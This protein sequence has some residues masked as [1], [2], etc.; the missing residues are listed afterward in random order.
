MIHTLGHQHRK[1]ARRPTAVER[2]HLHT[3]QHRQRFVIVDQ[4][5]GAA[6]AGARAQR[7]ARPR[8]PVA[9]LVA[10]QTLP[11][12]APARI[13]TGRTL[14]HTLAAA[15]RPHEVVGAL[16]ALVLAGPRAP[17]LTLAV[18]VPALAGPLAVHIQELA[19]DL[20]VDRK[21]RSE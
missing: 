15:A 21:Q 12:A 20:G 8:A 11:A 6:A 17:P 16:G 18:T 14:V 3:L 10:R 4:S 13:V 2:L 5:A 9:V 19:V 1:L 7:A